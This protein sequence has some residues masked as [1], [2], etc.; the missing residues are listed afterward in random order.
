MYNSSTYMG[1]FCQTK[2]HL[3][4]HSYIVVL[5][6]IIILATII[7]SATTK[8]FWHLCC[9]I[10][11]LQYLQILCESDIPCRYLTS[12]VVGNVLHIRTSSK[13]YY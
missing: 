1:R 7:E 11:F 12:C 2:S 4:C 5:S 8:E 9:W 6:A 10:R 3:Y 13:Q